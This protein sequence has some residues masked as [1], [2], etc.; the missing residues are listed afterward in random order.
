MIDLSAILSQ[1]A[2]GAGQGGAAPAYYWTDQSS[3]VRPGTAPGDAMAGALARRVAALFQP[4]TGPVFIPQPRPVHVPGSMSVGEAAAPV[5]NP[6]LALAH[7]DPLWQAIHAAMLQHMRAPVPH[8]HQGRSFQD[9]R[10][11][12]GAKTLLHPGRSDEDPRA[13]IGAATLFRGAR[14]SRNP[15]GLHW[16]PGDAIINPG[17]GL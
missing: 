15:R 7:S 16:Q 6:A 4:P 11:A 9:P 14:I 2:T 10:T 17:I 1:A 12:I 8:L 5:A 3:T 13:G